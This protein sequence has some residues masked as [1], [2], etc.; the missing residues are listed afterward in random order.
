VIELLL[1]KQKNAN[2][3]DLLGGAALKG[4]ADLI[5]VLLDQGAPVN[6]A[7]EEWIDGPARGRRLKGS[8]RPW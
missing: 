5:A 6:A 7:D 3:A 4:Q 1:K 2:L 8:R